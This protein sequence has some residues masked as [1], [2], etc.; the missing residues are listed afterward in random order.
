MTN[1]EKIQICQEVVNQIQKESQRPMCRL[2]LSRESFGVTDS[3]LGGVP[4]V[5]HDKQIPT[6]KNGS[7]LWLCAQI[8]FAQM[9]HMDGFPETGLLQIFLEDWHF[10]DFGLEGDLFPAQ[11]CWKAVYYPDIDETVTMEECE[12]KMSVPWA[13]AKRSNMPR[14]ANKFDLQDIERGNDSLWRCPE[15]PLKISFKGVEY[16]GVNYEDFRFETLFADALE[17]RL[18]DADPEEFMPYELHNN[19]TPEEREALDRIYRQIKSGGCKIGGY[20]SYLQDDPRMYDD[21]DEGWEECDTLLLQLYDDTYD[22]PQEDIGEMDLYLNG[23]PLNFVISAVDLKNRDF[24]KIL[25]Q[26][27]CT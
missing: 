5:P 9:P 18:P 2:H 3:H 14:L 17:K 22:Y 1:M 16:E 15:V 7:Q 8:N 27:A 24:S 26:W 4:Y 19:N 20:P 10:G 23:G 11:D 13:Q 21:D 12:A 6:D 25:A